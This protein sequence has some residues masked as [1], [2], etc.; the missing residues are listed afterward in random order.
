MSSQLE[1]NDYP[2]GSLPSE[3]KSVIFFLW[4]LNNGFSLIISKYFWMVSS[5][6]RPGPWRKPWCWRVFIAISTSC[7]WVKC[8]FSVFA[9][10]CDLKL[11]WRDISTTG[12]TFNHNPETVFGIK[13]QRISFLKTW[14]KSFLLKYSIAL[15]FKVW[16]DNDSLVELK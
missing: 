2:L 4:V 1:Q 10:Y 13:P 14:W 16:L 12:C 7:C 11:I 3:Q 5:W 15:A 6:R 8:S 9:H